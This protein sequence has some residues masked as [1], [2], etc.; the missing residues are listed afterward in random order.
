MRVVVLKTIHED[1]KQLK[2]NIEFQ[3]NLYLDITTR[4]LE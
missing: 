2:M 3:I 1:I 4:K